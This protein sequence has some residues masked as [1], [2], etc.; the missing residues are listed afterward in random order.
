MDCSPQGSSVHGI[1][2]ARILEWAA[3]SSS[4]GSFWIRDQTLVS[5]VGRWIF[6]FTT[7]LPGKTL[8]YIYFFLNWM[9]LLNLFSLSPFSSPPLPSKL[10][11]S[12][13]VLYCTAQA[14]DFRSILSA[15]PSLSTASSNCSPSYVHS[16][17]ENIFKLPCS[18]PWPSEHPYWTI[19]TAT[20][21]L[22]PLSSPLCQ[23]GIPEAGCQT[24][25]VGLHNSRYCAGMGSPN[26]KGDISD[27]H[28]KC[29]S[30]GQ[31]NS[32]LPTP[33]QLPVTYSLINRY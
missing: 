29:G 14:G 24:F 21:D 23:R 7:E 9:F 13:C 4:T 31:F 12:S 28:Q 22:L 25:I 2:Q 20:I 18:S 26:R 1:S 19:A 11:F 5:W 15:P 17:S 10:S 16:F 6:F 30:F 8:Y 3:I 33:S 32:I 27:F